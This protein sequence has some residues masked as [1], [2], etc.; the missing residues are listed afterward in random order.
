VNNY[1]IIQIKITIIKLV[2]NAKL[3]RKHNLITQI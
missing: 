3:N 1:P 2:R